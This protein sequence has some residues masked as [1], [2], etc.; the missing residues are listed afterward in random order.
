MAAWV[1][2]RPR[3]TVNVDIVSFT[4]AELAGLDEIGG[5]VDW[6]K[7]TMVEKVEVKKELEDE[8]DGRPV[9]KVELACE[10]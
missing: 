9:P 6:M 5:V 3:R 1:D 7:W 4:L 8:E 10:G 2:E